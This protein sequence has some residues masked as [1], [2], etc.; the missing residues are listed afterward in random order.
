MLDKQAFII[1]DMQQSETIMKAKIMKDGSL[2]TTEDTDIITFEKALAKAKFPKAVFIKEPIFDNI[3]NLFG[4]HA[5]I[6]VTR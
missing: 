2:G 4:R 1:L 5:E 6:L 3:K